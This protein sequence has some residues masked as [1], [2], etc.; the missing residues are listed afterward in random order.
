MSR[1]GTLYS[2]VRFHETFVA[3]N[4]R[5]QEYTLSGWCPAG[6]LALHI[7]WSLKEDE[8]FIRNLFDC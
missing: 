6:I 4:V 8:F 3:S 5:A 2:N 1:D 7:F